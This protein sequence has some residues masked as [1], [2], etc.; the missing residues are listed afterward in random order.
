[1]RRFQ[2]TPQKKLLGMTILFV[3]VPLFL[4]W[5]W[6]FFLNHKPG[7]D[8]IVILAA[9]VLLSAYFYLKNKKMVNEYIFGKKSEDEMAEQVS[10]EPPEGE[11][12]EDDLEDEE[13]VEEAK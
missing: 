7:N 11:E 6:V 5:Y 9:V 13:L 2:T 3:F 1:M 10:E 8:T 12:F 4:V